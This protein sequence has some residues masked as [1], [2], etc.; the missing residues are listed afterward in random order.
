M[1]NGGRVINRSEIKN[2]HPISWNCTKRKV[3][4]FKKKKAMRI[5]DNPG[6][7]NGNGAE[8]RKRKGN[9]RT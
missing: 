2:K 5:H 8:E 9:E 6:Q 4:H 7:E 3:R 1:T